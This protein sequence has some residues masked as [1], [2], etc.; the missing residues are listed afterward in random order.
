[1]DH[2]SGGST[3]DELDVGGVSIHSSLLGLS[4]ITSSNF[5]GLVGDTSL[6]LSLLVLGL[7]CCELDFSS[8]LSL[9]G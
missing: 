4:G 2:A 7:S 9:L 5:V 8:I 6:S 3:L 1:M